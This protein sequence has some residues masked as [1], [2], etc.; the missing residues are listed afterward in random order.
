MNIKT[1]SRTLTGIAVG[2]SIK[3]FSSAEVVV[4]VHSCDDA[5]LSKKAV[6]RIFIGKEKKVSDGKE[7]LPVNQAPSSVVRSAFR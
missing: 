2:C 7:V 4:V 1:F 5:A 6:Q 3:L